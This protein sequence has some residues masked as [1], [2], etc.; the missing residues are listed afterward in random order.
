MPEPNGPRNLF[1][2][3]A[4]RIL[5]L[6]LAVA[7]P[8]GFSRAAPAPS[9][10]ASLELSRP[11]RSWEF[12]AAVGTRAGLFG[13]ETGNLEAWV[14]PLKILRN[15]QLNFW[16]DG[17][18]LPGASLARTLTVRPESTTIL[19]SNNTFS[20]WETLFVP[21]HEQGAIIQLEVSTAEPLEIEAVFE[22]DFQLEWPA[23]LGG[24]FLYWDANLHAF[25]LGEEQRKYVALV[26]SPSASQSQLEYSTN[27]SSSKNNSFKLGPTN[28]GGDTKTIVIAASTQGQSEAEKI[29]RRLESGYSDL[30]QESATYYRTYLERT[31]QLEL[32]DSQLQQAYDWSRVSML[33]GLVTNPDLGTGLIAGYRTSFDSQRP[34]FA[35]FF[36][37][38]SMWTSLALNASGDFATSRTALEFL[39]KYQRA[40]GKVPHEISQAANLVPWF[41]NL[42]LRI[43]FRRRHP[44]VHHRRQ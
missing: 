38:D 19:Y 37:R 25:H 44:A 13:S 10:P 35:W 34:G 21:V 30:M 15:F 12:L 39:A 3:R 41:T 24:T 18:I 2:S 42:S 23:A 26:G 27:Y 31:V 7:M 36:G 16:I 11:V 17:Q 4:A 14:Y 40:D 43:R 8:G 32:P 29:Y 6:F 5:L 33:Q 9:G 20:V 28:K 22:R 1:R